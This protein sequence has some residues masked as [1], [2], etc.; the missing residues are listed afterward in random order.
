LH[1]QIL[2]FEKVEITSWNEKIFFK[3]WDYG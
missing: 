1:L 2:L 3:S